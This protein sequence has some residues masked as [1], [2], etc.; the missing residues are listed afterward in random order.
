MVTSLRNITYTNMRCLTVSNAIRKSFGKAEK[1]KVDE[2]LICRL[3]QKTSYVKFNVKYK[4]KIVSISKNIVV[5]ENVK[6]KQQ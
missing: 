1:Y 3:Y 5:L 4:F 6:S 2:I